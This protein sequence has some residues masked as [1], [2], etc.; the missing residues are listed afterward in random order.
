MA[1]DALARAAG[2]HRPVVLN[3][4][5]H[6]VEIMPGLSPYAQNT[7]EA[8]AILERL[9]AL[10]HFTRREGVAVVGLGDITGLFTSA[11]MPQPA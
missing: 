9:A 8:D 2:S 10:L 4:M 5:F 11:V 7:A 6:N 3:C 1:R